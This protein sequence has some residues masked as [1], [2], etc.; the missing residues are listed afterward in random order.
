MR[1][2]SVVR[3]MRGSTMMASVHP[4]DSSDS[5]QPRPV[6]KN[7]MPNRPNTMEGMPCKV[8]VVMR[9]TRTSLEPRGAYSTSQMAANTPSGVAMTSERAVISTVLMRAGTRDTLSEV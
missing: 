9:T 7:S 4:P 2:S 6:T 1:A 5:R 8:S 3:M